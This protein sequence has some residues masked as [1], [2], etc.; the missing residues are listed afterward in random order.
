MSTFL[1]IVCAH[2]LDIYLC[3][4][5]VFDTDTKLHQVLRFHFWTVLIHLFVAI[6]SR[7]TL[8]LSRIC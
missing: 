2:M 7:L 1:F 8:T 3:D 4:R 6:T 5:C